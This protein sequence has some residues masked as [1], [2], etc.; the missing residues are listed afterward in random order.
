MWTQNMSRNAKV[1]NKMG[2]RA[3]YGNRIAA[4]LTLDVRDSSV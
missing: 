3:D 2:Q 1:K 4:G